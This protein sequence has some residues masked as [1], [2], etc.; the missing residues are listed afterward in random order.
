MEIAE[1]GVLFPE[2]VD[3]RGFGP[4]KP[5]IADLD[6]GAPGKGGRPLVDMT[7]HRFG[8]LTV[9]EIVEFPSIQATVW[10]AQCDCGREILVTR[11]H[12][13]TNGLTHCGC[14]SR[15]YKPGTLGIGGKPS[16]GGY[17]QS[18]VFNMLYAS[19]RQGAAER[20]IGF[21]LSKQQFAEMID[22][23][24]RY[25]GNLLSN[26]YKLGDKSLAYNGIDRIDSRL[27]Y[28]A[29]NCAPCC[30]TCNRMKMAMDVDEFLAH[31]RAISRYLGLSD[32]KR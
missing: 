31:V 22:M 26:E 11:S 6:R 5:V 16:R 2:G 7:G 32:N 17:T 8:S 25:C 9:M 18:A 1:Q 20:G 4:R 3:G 10:A 12:L 13:K 21:C 28:T 15:K 23:P 24:C 14:L 19:Y 27:G 30:V 29:E